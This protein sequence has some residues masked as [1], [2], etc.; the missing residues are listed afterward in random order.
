MK[1]SLILSKVANVT[2]VT[3]SLLLLG[4]VTLAQHVLPTRHVREQVLSRQALPLGALSGD[5]RVD[6]WIVLQLRNQDDLN[7]FL[8]ELYDPLSASYGHYLSVQEFTGRFGPTEEDYDAVATFAEAS[9]MTVTSR[10]ANRLVLQVNTS[11]AN[12]ENALHLKLGVY[13]HPTENRTFYAPDREP[14]LDLTV[15]LWHIA[16]LDNFSIPQQAS[17]Q[18][19]AI[20]A[21]SGSGPG[22]D[23]TGSDMRAAYYGGA[24]LTGSG[25]T[26]GL[27]QFEAYNLSDVQTYFANLGQQLNVPIHNV[28]L[29]GGSCFGTCND[30]E[31]AL[32]LEQV[33]SMAPSLAQVLVYQVTTGFSIGA[34]VAIFNRMA[35]DNIAKQLSCSW[36]WSPADPTSDDPIFQEFAA[37]GQSLFAASGD[38]GSIPNPDGF[39]FPADDPYVTAVGGT[40]LTTAGPGGAWQSETG[41]KASGGGVSPDGYGIPSYQQLGGV[42]NSSNLGSTTIRNVPDVAAQSDWTNYLCFN[43]SCSLNWGGTS[44]AAPRWAAFV[45]LVNQYN[46]AHGKPLVGFLNPTIYSTGISPAYSNYFHDVTTGNNDCY[47]NTGCSQ[48][49]GYNAVVGYDLVTGWGSPVAMGWM[50]TFPIT[51]STGLEPYSPYNISSLTETGNTAT[52]TFSGMAPLY[53]LLRA[54]FGTGDRIQITG[55]PVGGYNGVWTVASANASQVTFNVTSSGLG[56]SSSGQ[57]DTTFVAVSGNFCLIQGETCTRPFGGG[58]SVTIAGAAVSSYNGTWTVRSWP[59]PL[60]QTGAF[61]VSAP[62]PLFITTPSGGGTVAPAQ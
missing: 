37:Q 44:F 58:T 26:V 60:G 32:D 36:F 29:G 45:A 24:T 47:P 52:A 1:V 57:M 62:N 27:L 49:S 25:Q 18:G 21:A 59:A 6:L 13:Q 41:W 50:L 35:T 14:S 56:S 54:G 61:N 46:L 51:P 55:S 30:S 2:L 11:V 4:T 15:P 40:D 23:F 34:D 10:F 28:T 22:G 31:A 5:T 38:W 19:T 16:G 39:Y 53:N 17:R 7:K 12:A 43:G 42:I 3:A 8:Q 20:D 48:S 9:G 33:I